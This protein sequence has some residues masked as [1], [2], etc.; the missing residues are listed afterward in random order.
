VVATLHTVLLS[1]LA[2]RTVVGK[3]WR[4]RNSDFLDGCLGWAIPLFHFS[5]P[6]SEQLVLESHPLDLLFDFFVSS[7]VRGLPKVAVVQLTL[8]RL[9][10]GLMSR[11]VWAV[12]LAVTLPE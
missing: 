7:E 5:H 8:K 4:C 11:E 3:L 12:A 9:D 1:T 10:S 6:L 2:K